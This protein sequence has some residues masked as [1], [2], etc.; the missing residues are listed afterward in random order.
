MKHFVTTFFLWVI[1][2]LSVVNAE[3]LYVTD[4]V[5]LG[6]HQEPKVESLLLNSIPSGTAVEVVER[7]G[8]F[9]KIKQ[10]DGIQGWVNSEYL[11]K[12]TPDIVKLRQLVT[13]HDQLG[14][15][16]ERLSAKYNKASE[17]LK[18]QR[19]ELKKKE[20]E[21]QIQ[22]DELA[23]ARSSINDLRQR[24]KMQTPAAMN[25]QLQKELDMGNKKIELLQERIIQ[26]K[27]E[28]DAQAIDLDTQELIVKIQNLEDEN[29][30]LQ[31]RINVAQANLSGEN[32][33]SPEELAIIRPKFPSWYWGLLAVMIIIGFILGLISIDYFYRK[34]HGGFRI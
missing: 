5:L 18:S 22:Q 3:T 16:H 4:K 1:A 17:R 27:S 26:Q 23:N 33:P 9:T 13:K 24:N 15:E 34:R 21:L 11:I 12:D 30:M 8:N 7:Y 19:N 14:T 2:G 32:I 25:A 6:V 20:R 28:L 29:H 10:A 31:T